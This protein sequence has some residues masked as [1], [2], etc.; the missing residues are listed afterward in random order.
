[1]RDQALFH[2]VEC[3]K[4]F[5]LPCRRLFA[6]EAHRQEGE[7]VTGQAVGG[8]HFSLG[9][10]IFNGLKIE[11]V[12]AFGTFQIFNIAQ[13]IFMFFLKGFRHDQRRG[14]HLTI[15]NFNNVFSLLC[16][17]FRSIVLAGFHVFS[18]CL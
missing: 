11:L 3:L 6:S 12:E 8:A 14:E 5:F 13:Y 16:D 4:K 2:G 17:G 15:I 7:A 10:L 9:V 1:M 18:P